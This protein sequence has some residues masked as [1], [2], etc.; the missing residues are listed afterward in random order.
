VFYAVAMAVGGGGSLVFGRLF[1]R[2]GMRLL[3][4]LTVA[5]AVYAPLAFLGG[6]WVSLVG[7][8]L[9]GLGSGVQESIIPAAVAGMVSQDRRAS[10]F[11]LFTG[12]YG[13]A[14][15]IGSTVIGLLFDISLPLVVAFSLVSE[16]AALPFFIAA[17]RRTT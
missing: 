16:L 15:F 11:G 3:V 10:A 8:I 5:A 6:F 9:W 13:V 14:W 12:G 7:V 2:F 1:D 4:P 17:R